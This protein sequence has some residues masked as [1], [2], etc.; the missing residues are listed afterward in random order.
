MLVDNTS[1]NTGCVG[2]LVTCLE[3]KIGHKLHTIGCALHQNELPFRAVF[4]HLDG[5][6]K[7]PS[8]FTGPL[9]KLCEIDHHDLPQVEFTKLSGDL[10]NMKL[11]EDTL[12]DLSS[13]Q[14][15]FLEYVQ[16]ISRGKV[17]PRL[18]AW[19]IGPLNHAR[20]LTLAIRLMCLW[21]R[22]TYTSELQDK[23]YQV[24]KYI[25]EVYAVS[26]FEI[27]RDSKFHNQPL[28][29]FNMIQRIQMQSEEIKAVAFNNLKYNAFAL[30]PENILLLHD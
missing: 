13:D 16:G 25:V 14:R 1:T 15:L 8:T 9:G 30:L 7:S 10:D 5:S 19:K 11:S 3:K 17:N 2:G 28:Y 26:W 27:K 20:W 24:I 29:I 6:T 22:G 4:K 12:N 21:T 18:A 23:L